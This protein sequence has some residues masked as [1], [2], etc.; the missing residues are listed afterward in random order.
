MDPYQ[1]LGVSSDANDD[2]VKA[3]YRTLAKKYHPDSY[4]NNPLADLAAEKMK[5]INQAYDQI[6]KMRQGGGVYEEKTGY[7]GSYS[8]STTSGYSTSGFR[9]IRDL[10][11]AGR[12]REAQ[13]VLDAVEQSRRNAEW[14]FLR[15]IVLCNV[16]YINEGHLELQNA[17][18]MDP[19]NP[20]YSQALERVN[21]QMNGGFQR[22]PYGGFG[23]NGYGNGNMQSSECNSCDL[24]ASLAC[25]NCLCGFG[26]C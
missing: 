17:V 10:I 3:A 20:E 21:S 9:N 15:G 1:V 16:G 23:G 24:C 11:N 19:G 7:G 12:I 26:G 4:A 6:T 8:G 14:H 22:R 18:Q 13:S 5:S 25:M 2:E